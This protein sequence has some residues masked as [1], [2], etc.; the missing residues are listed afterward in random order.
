[1]GLAY[2]PLKGTTRRYNGR[3]GPQ[4]KG[5]DYMAPER[6]HKITRQ[7]ADARAR[8]SAAYHRGDDGGYRY[9]RAEARRLAAI[10]AEG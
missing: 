9:A 10:L 3:R 2:D 6:L 8:M 4:S 1:M 5:P 7:L